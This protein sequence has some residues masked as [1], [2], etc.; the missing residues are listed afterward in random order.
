ML[1]EI[2]DSARFPRVHVVVSP[3]RL[4][5]SAKESNG[6]RYGTSGMKIGD[7]HCTWAFSAAAVH[8]LKN[9][10]P[11]TKYLTQLATRPGKGTALSLLAH[12]LGRAVYCMRKNQ[13]AFDQEPCLATSGGR[14][15]SSLASNWSHRA[16]GTHPSPRVERSCS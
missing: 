9:N 11:A 1:Y 2:A 12:K 10:E 13:G 5:N 8:L 3:C 16:R 15:R 14:E 7:A 4:V 6:Q